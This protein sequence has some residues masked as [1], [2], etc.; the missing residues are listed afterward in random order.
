MPLGRFLALIW[1]VSPAFRSTPGSGGCVS[2]PWFEGSSV[3]GGVMT[4]V[5]KGQ[6]QG[7]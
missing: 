6:K 7:S 3:P 5:Q 1:I 2:L 4:H